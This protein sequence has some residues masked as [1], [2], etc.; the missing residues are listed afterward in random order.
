MFTPFSR[1]LILIL[2]V[3]LSAIGAYL[4]I[5]TFLILSTFISLFIL[6]G[7][8]NVGT[9]FL[10]LGKMRKNDFVKAATLLDQIK[11]PDRL[12]KNYRSYFYFIRGI[13]A[14]EEDQFLDSKTCLLEALSIGIKKESDRAMALL[15]LTDMEMVNKNESQARNYFVQI[16]NLKVQQ[17]L[18]PHIRKMQE[19]L[20]V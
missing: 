17:A 19:W 2:C 5:W 7:Y 13:I 12:N 8:Y 20:K 10:A 4:G 14:H 3:I 15:A 6:Y 16:K 1:F 18:M 9:V 11:N